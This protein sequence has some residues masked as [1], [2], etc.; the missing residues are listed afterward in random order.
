MNS[1]KAAKLL[2]TRA[3]NLRDKVLCCRVTG[4]VQ[5]VDLRHMY[6]ERKMGG[7]PMRPLIGQGLTVNFASQLIP[8]GD[9]FLCS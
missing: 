6:E 3:W 9:H 8:L 4:D 5:L 1:L 2:R 7:L